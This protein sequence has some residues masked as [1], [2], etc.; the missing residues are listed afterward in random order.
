MNQITITV[1][2][3]VGVIFKSSFGVCTLSHDVEFIDVPCS[4][5]N[6]EGYDEVPY[7]LISGL[8][9]SPEHRRQGHGRALL[10]AAVDYAK[11]EF[12]HLPLRLSA[13]PDSDDV[14]LK[15][16]IDF[17]T[18]EGFEAIETVPVVCMEYRG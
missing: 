4:P 11:A 3:R 6:P 14:S 5:E 18:S 10:R 15:A 17:Y 9:V 2:K 7:V 1:D 13:V 12:P 8:D 16:L